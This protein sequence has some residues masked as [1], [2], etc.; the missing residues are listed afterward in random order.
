MG[1]PVKYS[2]RDGY[3]SF[4]SNYMEEVIPSK[5]IR[6]IIS[7]NK[8]CHV[9]V[10]G[11]DTPF[12]TY[13]PLSELEKQLP[14]EMFAKVNRATIVS[15]R[16]I[17]AIRNNT[18]TLGNKVTLK[19]TE[20]NKADLIRKYAK[21]AAD[22]NKHIRDAPYCVNDYKCKCIV[23]IVCN[24]ET[25]MNLFFHYCNKSFQELIDKI[26]KEKVFEKIKKILV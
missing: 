2:I 12:E 9:Y 3:L 26:G 22:N 8:K 7:I 25:D 21:Y 15:L 19:L 24:T 5:S 17:T 4:V 10:R 13:L 16:E 20:R 1:K 14:D 6:F 18:V 11:I 23:E